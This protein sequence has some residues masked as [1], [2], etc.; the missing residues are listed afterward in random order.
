MMVVI[1]CLIVLV[2][3][4]D[5]DGQTFSRMSGTIDDMLSDGRLIRVSSRVLGEGCKLGDTSCGKVL[6][7]SSPSD[8]STTRILIVRIGGSTRVRGIAGTVAREGTREVRSFSSC[9]PRR[10]GLLRSTRRDVHKECVF[11]TMSS[12]TSR[13]HD[14]FS[15]DL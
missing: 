13:C 4:T 5:K 7:C 14:T 12:G 6:C 3:C 9:L 15:G 1:K 8:V 2:L 11:F 10:M